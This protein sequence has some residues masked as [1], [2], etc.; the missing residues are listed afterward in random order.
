MRL[1]GI[2][3]ILFLGLTFSGED[4]VRWHSTG[5]T[6]WAATARQKTSAQ[7]RRGNA[8]GVRVRVTAYNPMWKKKRGHPRQTASGRW[9]RPGIVALSRDVERALGVTFGDQ[10]VL[11][12][13]GTFVFDDRVSIRHRR[14]ADIFMESYQAAREFGVKQAY[15]RV[16]PAPQGSSNVAQRGE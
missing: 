2:V 5:G 14:H 3:G 16:V 1:V 7:T 4:A 8:S 12:G 15:V 6:A 9:V 11:E 10:V 13:L